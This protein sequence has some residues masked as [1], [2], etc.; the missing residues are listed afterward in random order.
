MLYVMYC[1][2]FCFLSISFAPLTHILITL[3]YFLLLALPSSSLIIKHTYL[4]KKRPCI[5]HSLALMSSTG[6]HQK[7][8]ARG[9]VWTSWQGH[10]LA[11]YHFCD[12]TSY[13]FCV[14]STDIL[15]VFPW[16]AAAHRR[17]YRKE[18]YKP[19]GIINLPCLHYII[20]FIGHTRTYYVFLF[21][22]TPFHVIS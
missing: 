2:G 13:I 17:Y 22:L 6:P 14:A 19:F 7:R 11:R 20:V 15:C 9:L 4:N 18:V 10:A 5:K 3:Q 1:C 21:A 16:N 12:I 8:G